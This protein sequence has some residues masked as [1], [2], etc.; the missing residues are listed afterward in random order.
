M[1]GVILTGAVC[2]FAAPLPKIVKANVTAGKLVATVQTGS[3]QTKVEMP[4][5]SS[6]IGNHLIGEN[7]NALI[8]AIPTSKDFKGGYEN[9]SAGVGRYLAQGDF[10]ILLEAPLNLNRIREYRSKKGRTAYVV[11]MADG[12]AGIPYVYVC[13]TRGKVWDKRAVR[14]AG[15]RNGKLILKRFVDGEEAGYPD[16]KPIGMLY[17]DLDTLLAARR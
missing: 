12:G 14:V 7:G 9:E 1:A 17:L 15:A 16:A 2:A 5:Y 3:T 8:Y 4:N 11:S 13:S 6:P 10:T